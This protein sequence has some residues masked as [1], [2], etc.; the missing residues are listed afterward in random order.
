ML[1]AAVVG[2]LGG[3]VAVAAIVQLGRQVRAGE[4]RA[5]H[6]VV[7]LLV[8]D[9]LAVTDA[10]G[11]HQLALGRAGRDGAVDVVTIHAGGLSGG[12]AAA[13]GLGLGLSP[14]RVE[15]RAAA[16][17]GAAG[18][19]GH[20]GDPGAVLS[21]DGRRC[22]TTGAGPQGAHDAAAAITV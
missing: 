7:D 9:P 10:P 22:V 14:G 15:G 19:G 20:V 17:T 12:V 21:G 4:A 11:V 18:V 3:A 6:I 16:P 13:A 1:A 2:H 8:A 5:G